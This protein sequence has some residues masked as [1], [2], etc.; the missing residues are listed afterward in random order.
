M[1]SKKINALGGDPYDNFD[2]GLALHLLLNP[3][4]IIPARHRTC[5]D[6]SR[7]QRPAHSCCHNI[8]T[9]QVEPFNGCSWL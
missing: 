9:R 4:H 6:Q 5:R 7:K 1:F 2:A 3:L 8:L